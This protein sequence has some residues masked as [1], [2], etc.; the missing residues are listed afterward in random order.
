MTFRESSERNTTHSGEKNMT[1]EKKMV[2]V[3]SAK[4]GL[5]KIG[6]GY[7]RHTVEKDQITGVDEITLKPGLNSVPEDKWIL[8]KKMPIVISELEEEVLV[9]VSGSSLADHSVPKAQKLVRECND[10]DLLEKWKAEETRPSVVAAINEQFKKFDP[11][12][13]GTG[14]TK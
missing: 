6:L 10:K 11:A 2:L 13:K 1:D 14:K 12:P 7:V 3:K 8:A 9:E 4:T 5:Y